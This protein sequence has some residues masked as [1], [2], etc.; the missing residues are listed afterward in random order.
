MKKAVITLSILFT[1]STM[2]FA[3][4]END[5]EVLEFALN[6]RYSVRLRQ[7]SEDEYTDQKQKSQHLRHKPYKVI[8]DIAKAQKKLGRRINAVE[9]PENN[10][11]QTEITYKDGVR[12]ILYEHWLGWNKDSLHNF[13]AY[14]PKLGVLILY[15]ELGGDSPVDLNDSAK[16]DYVGNPEYHSVSPDKQF[17]INGYFPDGAVDGYIYFLEKWNNSNK[18]YEF[19]CLLKGWGANNYEFFFGAASDWFW[20]SNSKVLFSSGLS[21][22][23][24]SWQYCEMEFIEKN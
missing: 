18:K 13:K 12:K 11:Y 23:Y 17:R 9:I 2:T 14:Y 5:S 3:Q 6:D 20:V 21:D 19:A 10:S 24:A 15:N 8:T 7:I 16:D 4:T 22:W 1:L